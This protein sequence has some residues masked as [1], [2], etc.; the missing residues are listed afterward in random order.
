MKVS[1]LKTILKN[2]VAIV[3]DLSGSM[4]GLT[5]KLKQVFDNQIRVLRDQSLKFEQETRVSVYTFNSYSYGRINIECL[6]SDVDVA[7]PMELE[8]L[9][10]NGGTP[11]L[12]A[13]GLAIEDLQ[14]LPQKYGDHAFIVYVLTDGEE[15]TSKKYNAISFAKMINNLPSNFMVLGF[16]PNNNGVR[17]LKGFGFSEGNIE[18][19]DT[20]EK[21]LEEVG[22]TF[23]RSMD[24][25]F[26]MRS[27][28]VRTS[29]TMFSDLKNV[30][31]TQVKQVLKEVKTSD[32][33]I[34]I[35]P[36]TQ[37]VEI[38]DLVNDKA[39]LP[40]VKGKA[41]YELVKNEHVQANKQIAIQNKKTGKVFAGDEARSLLNL[42]SYE[43][44][45][46]PADHGEWIVFIQSNSVNRKIIPKER[47]LVFK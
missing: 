7:R 40:F 9:S 28:G 11:L 43:V 37:A 5:A 18:K 39:K 44:K 2:H 1:G 23:E 33:E 3:L 8:S 16:V 36:D 13:T 25:Y 20:T 14:L 10:A 30:N 15:N 27:R 34:V 47:V 41:F 19:W 35:N 26:T 21:G 46:M 32:Y 45:I 6:I 4:Q 17:Y 38:R 31:Q 22:K 12:D 42:P 24:S 29:D